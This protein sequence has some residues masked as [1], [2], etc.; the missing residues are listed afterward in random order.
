MIQDHIVNGNSFSR[1]NSRRCMNE[2]DESFDVPDEG[3]V[4]KIY[5]SV[6]ANLLTKLL[7]KK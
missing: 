1:K 2:E 7:P 5:P 4:S 3:K 6:K